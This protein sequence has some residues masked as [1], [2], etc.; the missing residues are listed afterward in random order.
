M[1][2]SFCA[3]QFN[4]HRFICYFNWIAA[5]HKVGAARS[6]A[7]QFVFFCFRFRFGLTRVNFTQLRTCNV[8]SFWFFDFTDTA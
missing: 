7:N 8:K 3:A 4:R 6:F 2:V 5:D 1:I